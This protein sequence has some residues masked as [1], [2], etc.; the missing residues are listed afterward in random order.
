MDDGA[1][2][3]ATF[4]LKDSLGVPDWRG[5]IREMA[6]HGTTWCRKCVPTCMHAYAYAGS[7]CTAWHVSLLHRTQGHA[8]PWEA[9][10]GW[11]WPQWFGCVVAV[12][13]CRFGG[14]GRGPHGLSCQA[15]RQMRRRWLQNATG[16]AGTKNSVALS[17]SSVR[18]VLLCIISWYLL[19]LSGCSSRV[20]I[21][22]NPA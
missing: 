11:R 14:V 16:N 19:L 9:A 4:K 21:S 18:S 3:G 1:D 17:G 7:F 2:G 6:Q 20:M 8:V 22:D 13:M 10:N 15:A 12:V 5:Y